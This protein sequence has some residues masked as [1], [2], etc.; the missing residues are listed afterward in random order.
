MT[1]PLPHSG[2]PQSLS[3]TRPELQTEDIPQILL[4]VGLL[5]PE[6]T[7]LNP[8]GGEPQHSDGLIMRGLPQVYAIYLGS[9]ES[10]IND[11]SVYIVCEL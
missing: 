2:E 4:P 1:V 11:I 6:D 10:E 5:V 8:L 9:N 7:Q 3:T